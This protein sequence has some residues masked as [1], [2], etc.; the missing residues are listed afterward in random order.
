M[1][2][3]HRHQIT[4]K[5]ITCPGHESTCAH[6]TDK[7][8]LC[9]GQTHE[10]LNLEFT[11]DIGHVTFTLA[12]T[13][14]VDISRDQVHTEQYTWTHRPAE[15]GKRGFGFGV[16]TLCND[17]PSAFRCTGAQQC[18]VLQCYV[19]QSQL[20]G[21]CLLSRTLSDVLWG[22][23]SSYSQLKALSC[24]TITSQRKPQLDFHKWRRNIEQ[25]TVTQ[26]DDE[27]WYLET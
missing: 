4:D 17:Q 14:N 20:P 15:P 3:Y 13:R 1:L 11:G 22:L 10:M 25:A 9:I 21:E 27:K 12:S 18:N 16:S 5:P 26:K 19:V 24:W 6:L 23:N 8:V 7:R 2:Q